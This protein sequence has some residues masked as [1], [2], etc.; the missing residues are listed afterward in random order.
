MAETDFYDDDEAVK[1]IQSHL[2]QEAQGH[3]SDDE[4]LYITDLIFDY[5]E[6]NGFFDDDDDEI[7]VDIEE[8]LEYVMKNA[9]RD[10]FHFNAELV[11]WVIEGEF[12][13][14]E[15]LDDNEEASH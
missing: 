6:S 10:G 3:F 1:F 4:V 15:S 12:D 9:K 8:L 5:Y 11:R 13:Y 14:E 2:P 7:D